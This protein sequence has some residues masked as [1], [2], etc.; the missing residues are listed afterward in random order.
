M[1]RFNFRSDCGGLLQLTFPAP[2]YSFRRGNFQVTISPGGTSNR[3]AAAPL[4]G[5]FKEGGFQRGEAD[6]PCQG[7]MAVGQ[8]G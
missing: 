6:S 5:R 4:I 8:K 3:G 7:E 2:Y 1:L